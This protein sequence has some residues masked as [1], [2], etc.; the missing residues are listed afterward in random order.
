MYI[1]L[2]YRDDSLKTVEQNK[3]D[4]DMPLEILSYKDLY[5]WS[6]DDIVKQV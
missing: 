1:F 5:G 3:T 6:M 2:G 4:Y